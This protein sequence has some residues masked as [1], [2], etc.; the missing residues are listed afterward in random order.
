MPLAGRFLSHSFLVSG[1]TVELEQN[2]PITGGDSSEVSDGLVPD[3][4]LVVF[5]RVRRKMI[6]DLPKK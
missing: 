1:S 4:G 3:H 6:C 5:V 2:G